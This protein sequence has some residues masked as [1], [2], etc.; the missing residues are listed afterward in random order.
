M[1]QYLDSQLWVRFN[2]KMTDLRKQTLDVALVVWGGFALWGPG[3]NDVDKAQAGSR[4]DGMC[5]DLV[6]AATK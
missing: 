1:Q 2:Q 4:Y 3:F 5:R 6:A